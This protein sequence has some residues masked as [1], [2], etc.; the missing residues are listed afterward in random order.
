MSANFFSNYS[1]KLISILRDFDWSSVNI[2]AEEL[3]NCWNNGGNV[4]LCGNGGSA[5][6]AS[7]LANDFIYG[8]AKC[9][10]EG[11]K[12][13]SLNDNI[14]VLTCLA[15]DV[16]YDYVFSEQLAV[17]GKKDDILIALSGSGNSMNIVNAIL[18]AKSLKM[19]THAILGF[20]GGKCKKNVEN[21]IHFAVNDMQLSEDLQLI[22]GHMAMK[23]LYNSRKDSKG[24]D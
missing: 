22:V 13:I 17:L 1:E 11:L 19:K 10:G 15:N 6:N 20:D 9:K 16:G 23:W 2:L 12:S 21:S 3:D 14:S 18:E 24:I 7:H 8:I 5:G 4:Y